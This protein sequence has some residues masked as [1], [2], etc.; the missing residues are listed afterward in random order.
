[1][2]LSTVTYLI[3]QTEGESQQVEVVFFFFSNTDLEEN[4]GIICFN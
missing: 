1:M 3:N 2:I 4:V